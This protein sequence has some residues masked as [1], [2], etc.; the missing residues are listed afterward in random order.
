MKK[1]LIAAILS[2]LA[3]SA[4]TQTGTAT[5]QMPV[6]ARGTITAIGRRGNATIFN[7]RL[8]IDAMVLQRL[9]TGLTGYLDSAGAR[10]VEGTN[11][12]FYVRI[13]ANA[14]GMRNLLDFQYLTAGTSSEDALR[15]SFTL[16]NAP[17]V[18]A[19]L[20]AADRMGVYVVVNGSPDGIDGGF[21]IDDHALAQATRRTCADG[22]ATRRPGKMFRHGLSIL[23]SERMLFLS[24]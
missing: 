13:E 8:A 2:N 3:T 1:I 23:R 21:N 6:D 10:P 4:L 24:F 16:P 17:G 11:H 9:S 20:E 22:H 12:I 7:Q 5:V 14:A 19:R 18:E 15:E